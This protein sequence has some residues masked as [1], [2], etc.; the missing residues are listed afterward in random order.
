[1][2][3]LIFRFPR[4]SRGA[5]ESSLAVNRNGPDASNTCTDKV[6]GNF[7]CKKKS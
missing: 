4:I 6:P 5:S 2:D 7:A 1:M 3:Q